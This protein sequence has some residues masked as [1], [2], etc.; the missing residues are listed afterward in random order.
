LRKAAILEPEVELAVAD[1][2]GDE[3]LYA[4]WLALWSRKPWA[5]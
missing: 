4:T 1:E 2:P 5:T 3:D